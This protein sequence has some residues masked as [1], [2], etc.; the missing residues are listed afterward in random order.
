[1]PG[2]TRPPTAFAVTTSG[3]TTA[4]S[5]ADRDTGPDR[6]LPQRHPG[7]YAEHPQH[8]PPKGWREVARRGYREFSTDQMSLIAAGVAFKAFLSIVPAIIAA[9][10]VYGLVADPAQV[11]HQV[12][13]L[14][15]V[16]PASAR[17]LLEQQLTSLVTT[18]HSSLGI[19]LVSSLLLSLW[20]AS[21]G[22]G[23]LVQ[24]VN[25]AYDETETRTWIIRKALALVLTVGAIIV[26]ALTTTLVAVFPAAAN[27][28]NPP[29]PV[30]IGLE[31]ARW[32][33]VLLVI[34]ISLAIL[35]RV[36][37]DRDAPR[38]QWVSVGAAVATVLWIV[39]SLGF[40]FYVDRFSSYGK[41]YGSLAGVVVLLLWIW[42]SVCAV[43][44]GA[45]I[46]AEAEK[47]T[48]RDTTVGE[49][50]PQGQRGA[51]KADLGPDDPE[52]GGGSGTRGGRYY[53][54]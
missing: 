10:L 43:L 40:S 52:P 27:A 49:P 36:A 41:T 18:N 12:S 53:S 46:N 17:D 3:Y 25:D 48:V 26:F 4:V 44:L 30:R 54:G 33:V 7:A 29:A 50:V 8:I 31:A 39:V 51:L 15:G 38:M 32:V 2:R 42:L 11:G 13:S 23:N 22:T 47:Q 1:M 28:L 5:S 20:S 45:E 9:I 37:P 16:L 24:A 21:G 19:G 35:Y 6:T 34:G 14:S